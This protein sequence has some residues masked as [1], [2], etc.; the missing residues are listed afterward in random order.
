[1]IVADCD[2]SAHTELVKI[3]TT[4]ARIAV[5]AEPADAATLFAVLTRIDADV[6]LVESRIPASGGEHTLDA[7]CAHPTGLPVALIAD[8]DLDDHVTAALRAGVRAYLLKDAPPETLVRAV[9]DVAAGGAVAD[10]RMLARWL[11]RL[12]AG[13]LTVETGRLMGLSLRERQVLQ[14]LADGYPNAAIGARLGLTEATVK[15]YVSTVLAKL[16]VTNRVQAA[17][18]AHRVAATGFY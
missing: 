10:P 15:S 11:P 13:C 3:L 17:L 9:L 2:Q 14:L 1:V 16:N 7:L 4:D 12:R 18:L 8:F 5:V 6:V